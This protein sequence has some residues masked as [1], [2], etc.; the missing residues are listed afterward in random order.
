[1][2]VQ[3]NTIFSMG[4]G[5][6]DVRF[7]ARRSAIVRCLVD[8]GATYTVVTPELAQKVGAPIFPQR[9]SVT[10]ADGRLRRLPACSVGVRVHGRSGPTTALILPKTPPLLGIETLESLGLKVD[11]TKARVEATRSQCAMLVGARRR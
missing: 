8:T 9:F 11:P 7:S 3:G 1:M 5:Y 4:H 2:S 10:V 6:V